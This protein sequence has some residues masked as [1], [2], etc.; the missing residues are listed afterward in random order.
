MACFTLMHFPMSM[1]IS[2]Y[3]WHIKT[4]LMRC[5]MRGIQILS[6]NQGHRS[7]LWSL[8]VIY[9]RCEL[10]MTAVAVWR[11]LSTSCYAS[12]PTFSLS[13]LRSVMTAVSAFLFLLYCILHVLISLHLSILT[14][15][16]LS[17]FFTALWTQSCTRCFCGTRKET[18]G[19]MFTLVFYMQY[20]VRRQWYFFRQN[21]I[22]ARCL[23]KSYD[24]DGGTDHKIWVTEKISSDLIRTY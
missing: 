14:F 20:Y 9:W 18:F 4:L 13:A 10:M 23:L 24:T 21:I 2:D 11:V 6:V 16:P 12:N 7:N 8:S 19:T 3:E 5:M 15:M 17:L 1:S 22:T